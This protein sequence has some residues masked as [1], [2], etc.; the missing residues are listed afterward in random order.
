MDEGICLAPIQ[1]APLRLLIADCHPALRAGVRLWMEREREHVQVQ[2]HEQE[3]TIEVV[4]EAGD[5]FVAMELLRRLRPDV[6][7]L[8]LRMRRL[9]AVDVVRAVRYDSLPTRF[10]VLS[11]VVHWQVVQRALAA[12]VHG[13]VH[14]EAPLDL[15]VDAVRHVADGARVL[16]PGLEGLRLDSRARISDR[17]REVLELASRGMPN[18]RIA[19][20]LGLGEETVKSHVASLMRKLGAGSRTEAVAAALRADIIS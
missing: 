18:R 20:Q 1:Q 7:L 2:E 3:P 4:G 12:G 11:S 16:P 13:F 5:G 19:E 6:A 14:K 9:D 17:E 15:V 8:D 10:V